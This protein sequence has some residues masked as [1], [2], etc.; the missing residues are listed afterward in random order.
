MRCPRCKTDLVSLAIFE[1]I[2]CP[3]CSA[4]LK[5]PGTSAILTSQVIAYV[6]AGVLLLLFEPTVMTVVVI[7][8][9][10]GVLGLAGAYWYRNQ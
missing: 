9:A 10:A 8:I 6:V 2:R 5:H 3:N 4:K 7:F 1:E